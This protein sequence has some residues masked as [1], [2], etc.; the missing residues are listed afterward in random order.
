MFIRVFLNDSCIESLEVPSSLVDI[1]TDELVK[2]CAHL[3]P[4]SL[5]MIQIVVSQCYGIPSNV[6]IHLN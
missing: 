4:D 1:K 3:Y 5:S 6:P 2:K